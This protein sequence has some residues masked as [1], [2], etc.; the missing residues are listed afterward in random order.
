[1][2]DER[3]GAKQ[4]AYQI[5]TGPTPDRLT[6][7]DSGR[8]DRDQCLHVPYG[9]PALVSRQRVYWAVR[10]WDHEGLPTQYG[11]PAFFEAGLL[12]RSDWLGQW[13]GSPVTGGPRTPAP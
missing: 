13:I 3:T 6:A 1:M 10:V 9:G 5:I 2:D 8:V 11:K 4:L 7:W 12:H